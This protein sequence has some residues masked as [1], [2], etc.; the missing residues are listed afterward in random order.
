MAERKAMSENDLL[1]VVSNLENNATSYND[2]FMT[3]NEELLR[4]Y[5]GEPYGDEEEGKSS[6]LATDVNDTVLSY[7]KI[8]NCS[9]VYGLANATNSIFLSYSPDGSYLHLYFVKFNPKRPGEGNFM[10]SARNHFVLNF[11]MGS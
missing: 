7:V 3:E 9:P 11:I 8:R 2:E 10:D 5:N 6:V 1:K 4:R